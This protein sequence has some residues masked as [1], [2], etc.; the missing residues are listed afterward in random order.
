MSTLEVNNIKKDSKELDSDY[1]IDGCA[2]AWITEASQ[3][4]DTYIDSFNISSMTDIGTGRIDLT[5]THVMNNSD[6][7]C[8]QSTTKN[9]YSYRVSSVA[10][11]TIRAETVD[12]SNGYANGEQNV[13]AFGDLA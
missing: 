12:G 8:F 4:T 7:S 13:I 1:V 3:N 11:S 2:K 9:R 10:T 6:F 5:L